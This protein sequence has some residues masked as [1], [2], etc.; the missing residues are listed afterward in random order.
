MGDEDEGDADV[1]LERLQLDLQVLAQARVERA[2]RLVEQQHARRE[3]EGAGERDALLLAAGELRRLAALEAR[4]SCTS[5]STSRD[6]P[7]LLLLADAAG[8]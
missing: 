6:L 2:E 8:T 3:D 4:C 7:A 1:R 5:S